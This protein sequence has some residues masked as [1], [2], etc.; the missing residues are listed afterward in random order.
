VNWLFLAAGW[1][2]LGLGLIGIFLPLLPTTPFLILAA[3]CFSK[4]SPRLHA[5]LLSHPRIGPLIIAWR[6]R[7]VIPLRAKI[8][9][10]ALLVPT[11]GFA[12]FS[13]ALPPMAKAGLLALVAGVLVFIWTKKSR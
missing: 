6:E 9:A 12:F 13:A 2:S 5:W 10:S 8:L 11:V 4:G 1:I 3:F 7:R